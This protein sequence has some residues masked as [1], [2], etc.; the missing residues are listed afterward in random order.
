MS[1]G[2]HALE[3]AQRFAVLRRFQEKERLQIELWKAWVALR[4]QLEAAEVEYATFWVTDSADGF[5]TLHRR[6]PWSPENVGWHLVTDH[7]DD[8]A[9]NL[10]IMRALL[11]GQV[12]GWKSRP[13]TRYERLWWITLPRLWHRVRAAFRRHAA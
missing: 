4:P 13:L 10:R 7:G 6:I 11:A 8:D 2:I 3:Q 12:N 1:G 9:G 5:C